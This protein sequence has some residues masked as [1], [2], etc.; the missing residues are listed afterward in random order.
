MH[1]QV[2]IR[3]RRVQPAAMGARQYAGPRLDVIVTVSAEVSSLC[4]ENLPPCRKGHNDMHAQALFE[5]LW[6]QPAAGALL[7]HAGPDSDVMVNLSAELASLGCEPC[8]HA[9]KV[10]MRCMRRCISGGAG[11]A[12]SHGRLAACGR[13]FRCHGEF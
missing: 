4:F 8:L 10:T 3:G 7:Q 13:H 12:C 1:A 5:G 6:A 11:A 2:L 9:E